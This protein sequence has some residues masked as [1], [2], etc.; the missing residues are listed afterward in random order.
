MGV[1]EWH[2]PAL[3][4]ELFDDTPAAELLTIIDAAEFQAVG[5]GE[6]A[7]RY[8]LWE[9][10]SHAKEED[11]DQWIG[12]ALEL[13]RLLLGEH[14]DWSCTVAREAKRLIMHNKI[15][16]LLSRLKEDAA[17]RVVHK[18]YNDGRRWLVAKGK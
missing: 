3:A 17:D 8:K 6:G 9:L 7:E 14:G 13:E 11:D 4:L 5:S 16:R 2:H 10:K 1:K 18:R 15:D 12:S